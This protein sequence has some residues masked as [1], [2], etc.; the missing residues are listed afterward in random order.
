MFLRFGMIVLGPGVLLAPRNLPAQN[1]APAQ[2]A[3]AQAERQ[4][5]ALANQSRAQAGLAPL[6]WDAALAHAALAHAQRMAA[7]GPIAHRYGGEMSLAERTAAAGAHFRLVEENIAVG[8][9]AAQIHD[10]W[11]HSEEHR[12]NLLNPAIDRIGVALVATRGVLYAVAD[13]SQSVPTLTRLQVEQQVAS[14]TAAQGVKTSTAEPQIAQARQA[15]D[16]SNGIPSDPANQPL[17][18]MRWQSASLDRLPQ[19]LAQRIHSGG[20]HVAAVGA[21][22][23]HHDA[24]PEQAAFTAYRIAVLLY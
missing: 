5:V 1:S 15:C 20:Y 19:A 7:E 17:F 13:Y 14:L 2:A 22:Q 8:Q 24:G 10:L 11:M 9:S 23:P 21:C 18:V 12:A 16:Q 4:L 3:V 6:Q